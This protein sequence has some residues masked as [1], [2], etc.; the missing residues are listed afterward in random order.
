[1]A[2]KK[3]MYT[4]SNPSIHYSNRKTKDA[5]SNTS[6]QKMHQRLEAS[7]KVKRLMLIQNSAIATSLFV[8]IGS[9]IEGCGVK[10]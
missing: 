1:M 8:C 7:I 2:S 10:I 3:N 4:Y 9:G 5:S 6:F